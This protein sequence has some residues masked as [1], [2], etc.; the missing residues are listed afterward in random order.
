MLED[1]AGSGFAP[2][3][4]NNSAYSVMSYDEWLNSDLTGVGPMRA[5][6]GRDYSFLVILRIGLLVIV[7]F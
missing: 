2:Q 5:G 4:S 6:R 3:N 7:P 1:Q